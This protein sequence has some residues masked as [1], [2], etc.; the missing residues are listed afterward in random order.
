MILNDNRLF[1]A[2]FCT[3]K[4]NILPLQAKRIKL[5]NNNYKNID[6]PMKHSV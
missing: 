2:V 5:K 4:K 3:Y 1:F 6:L